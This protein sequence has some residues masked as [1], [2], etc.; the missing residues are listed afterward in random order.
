MADMAHCH[1]NQSMLNLEV[2][3]FES[4]QISG[5]KTDTSPIIGP[6]P[7]NPLH[8]RWF[9]FDGDVELVNDFVYVASRRFRKKPKPNKSISQQKHQ[10]DHSN[11]TDKLS[12]PLACL[13]REITF[14]IWRD[15][16]TCFC[17]SRHVIRVLN[18]KRLSIQVSNDPLRFKAGMAY[19]IEMADSTFF[20]CWGTRNSYSNAN[21][22]KFLRSYVDVTEI[23]PAHMNWP[24]FLFL[25]LS[26]SIDLAEDNS[27]IAD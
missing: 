27:I 23:I 4:K 10:P 24:C 8:F 2:D 16:M 18:V 3:Q 1:C 26:G 15:V 7:K 22:R 19:E 14:I 9:C 5:N 6:F 20:R 17:D 12:K 25:A 13:W 11:S 21:K